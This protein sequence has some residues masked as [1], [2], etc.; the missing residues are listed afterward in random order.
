MRGLAYPKPER[1]KK[2]KRQQGQ[3]AVRQHPGTCYLCQVMDG[4]CSC[5]MTELH[6]IFGG[7][8]RTR[9]HEYGLVVRLCPYHHRT[10]GRD[11]VHGNYEIMDRMHR[12]GQIMFEE[13]HT[14]EEF[15]E[16]FG[17]NYLI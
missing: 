14:R 12:V 5:K 2:K 16:L 17:R 7:P 10:G 6:H 3:Q 9:S 11:S 4:D 13:T 15:V 1:K 8:F